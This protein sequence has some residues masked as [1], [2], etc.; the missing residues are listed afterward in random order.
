MIRLFALMVTLLMPL[1][2][3]SQNQS[4]DSPYAALQDDL[5]D[6]FV[7]KWIVNGTT[8]RRPTSSTYQVDWVL[9][10]Q[11]LRI[12]QKSSENAFGANVPYES[13]MMVGYDATSGTYVLHLMNV[14]GGRDARGIAFGRRTVNEISFAYY[15][16]APPRVNGAAPTIANAAP[17][18]GVRF[19]WEPDSKSWRLVF[20]SQNAEGE[21]Q[22]V[23]DLK[24]TQSK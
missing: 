14:R 11:F 17:R 5:L 8:H 9:N 19:T 18:P 1:G 7:G 4:P 21:W 24:A 3:L 13:I 2:A 23:T 6:H 16:I 15:D 20:G 12:G 10:H 22:T